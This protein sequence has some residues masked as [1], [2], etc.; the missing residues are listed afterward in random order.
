MLRGRGGWVGWSG[1]FKGGE[2]FIGSCCADQTI[3]KPSKIHPGDALLL[4]VSTLIWNPEL[5]E[6]RDED[7]VWLVPFCFLSKN[8]HE[9]LEN[10]LP[11]FR[12][13]LSS[14]F[15][16]REMQRGSLDFSWHIVCIEQVIGTYILFSFW[17]VKIG[18]CSGGARFVE[19]H[20]KRRESLHNT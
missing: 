15:S 18:L 19:S 6:G 9:I 7:M 8:A 11:S 13:D 3:R 17:I 20:L 1:R 5:R 2:L 10:S 14:V 4:C 16:Y 12:L